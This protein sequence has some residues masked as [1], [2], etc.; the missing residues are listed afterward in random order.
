VDHRRSSRAALVT[1]WGFVVLLLAG[2]CGDGGAQG[3]NTAL[4][5]VTA[6]A[7]KQ[8]KPVLSSVKSA[9]FGSV[10]IDARGNI[11]YR[12]DKDSAKPPRSNCVGTCVKKWPP[13]LAGDELSTK[14]IDQ[15]LV[16]KIR[17]PDGRWQLTLAGWPLYRYVADRRTSDLKGQNRDGVWFAVAPDGTK[18][19]PGKAAD[20]GGSGATAGGTRTKW[21]PLSAVDRELLVK[22]R[23]AWLWEMPAAQQ[24]GQRAQSEPVKTAGRQLA[25]QRA[26]VD[27]EV[28]A[29]ATG[30]RVTLPAQ[31]DAEHRTWMNELSSVR[32][33][34]YD[35]L[36]VNRIRAEQAKTLALAAQVRAS[37]RNSLIRAFAQRAVETVMGQMT[38]LERTGLVGDSTLS[39]S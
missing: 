3:G 25:A 31:P 28:R 12:Y 27:D 35:A 11:L 7:P 30:L 21:G 32:G 1:A 20:G 16:G 18:A 24:A 10:V 29:A 36:F 39:A 8:K 19:E 14:G 38:L 23:Q 13:V 9:K 5:S 26:D 17:R 33:N 15:D 22:V 37:T 6:S 4:P 2:A 34:K